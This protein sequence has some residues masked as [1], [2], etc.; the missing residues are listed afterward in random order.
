MLPNRDEETLVRAP[1]RKP[2]DSEVFLTDTVEEM[3][4]KVKASDV[5][6]FPAYF[7]IHGEKVNIR[8]YR[9]QDAK[10]QTEFDI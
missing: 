6:R 9:N 8:L 1:K 10:R 7:V 5:N 2:E 4:R 3:F